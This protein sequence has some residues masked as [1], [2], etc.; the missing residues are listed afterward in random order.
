MMNIYLDK[1]IYKTADCFF[2]QRFIINI[3]NLNFHVP[4]ACSLLSLKMQDDPFL[5]PS[6]SAKSEIHLGTIIRP[7]LCQLVNRKAQWIDQM[8]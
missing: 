8:Q 7:I 2:L 5:Y 4:S 1:I 6:K 3:Q